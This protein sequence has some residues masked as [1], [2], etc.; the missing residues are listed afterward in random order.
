VFDLDAAEHQP[1]ARDERVNVISETDAH[2]KS[3][4]AR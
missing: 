2:K 3:F 4:I 1:P